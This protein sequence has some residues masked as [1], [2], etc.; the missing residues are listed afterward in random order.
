MSA[1]LSANSVLTCADLGS[2]PLTA[3]FDRYG[4]RIDWVPDGA[5]IPGSHWG[6]AEAGLIGDRLLLRA[7]TPVHSALHEGSHYICM[8]PQR[9]A[10]L[11]TNAGGTRL[12]EEAV[13]YLQVLLADH[14]PGVGRARVFADMDAW[15]YNFCLGSAQAWFEQDATAARA[16]LHQ[17]AL[18]DAQEQPTWRVRGG[19]A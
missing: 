6:D 16:W 17:H 5:V 15:G 10:V 18:I 14:L 8:T 13:C 2:A 11:H 19:D 1:T 3:L 7:D 9:R 12:E 4:L